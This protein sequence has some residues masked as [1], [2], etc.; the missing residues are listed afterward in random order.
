MKNPLSLVT[1][2]IYKLQLLCKKALNYIARGYYST[3]FK[4]VGKNVRFFPFTSDI[5]YR[6]ISIGDDVY[7]GPSAFFIC[8][9]APIEIGSK[10]LMGPLV[11]IITGQHPVAVK[12]LYIY[13]NKD[14]EEENDLPVVIKDDVWIGAGATILKGSVIERG[15]I[16]AAG[17]LVNRTIPPYAIAGGVPAKVLRYRGTREELTLHEVK[18]Y[19]KVI[20]DFS[21]MEDRGAITKEVQ[22]IKE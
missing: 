1:L 4:S 10:I 9:I 18:L 17:A 14:K 2:P 21:F 3:L 19:G 6:N 15:A 5:H 13:D 20:T 11:T 8:S 12:G 22:L 7:I 16:I